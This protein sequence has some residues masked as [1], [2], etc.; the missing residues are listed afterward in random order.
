MKLKILFLLFFGI[1][2]FHNLY[3]QPKPTL[4]G[5]ITD[6]KTG[7]PLSRT[8]ILVHDANTG[9]ISDDKGY[10]KTAAIS[11]GTYVLEISH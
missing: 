11:P 9:T 6:A 5:K 2:V 3:S 7:E 8:S 1:L 10:Y 4:S